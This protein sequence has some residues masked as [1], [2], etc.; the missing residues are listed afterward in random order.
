ML[1]RIRNR[2]LQLFTEQ[3]GSIE[4]ERYCTQ[5]CSPLLVLDGHQKATRRVRSVTD[6]VIP[7]DELGYTKSQL[8]EIYCISNAFLDFVGLPRRLFSPILT[9]LAAGGVCGST[10]IDIDDVLKENENAYILGYVRHGTTCTELN[11]ETHS[12]LQILT[13]ISNYEPKKLSSTYRNSTGATAVGNEDN[14]SGKS[15][16]NID[17]DELYY[18]T[19]LSDLICLWQKN[20]VQESRGEM[21]SVSAD[22]NQVETMRADLGLTF[23]QKNKGNA[24]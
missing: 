24:Q 18:T 14:L 17:I 15:E 20:D 2:C 5:E 10:S 21:N 3:W 23:D 12:P 16:N 4:H 19:I 11:T 6:L 8:T 9:F 22:F 13:I 1:L 7:S